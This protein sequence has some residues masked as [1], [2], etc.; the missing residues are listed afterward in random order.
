MTPETAQDE[1]GWIELMSRLGLSDL[2]VELL[3]Q[4][5]THPSYVAESGTDACQS[6]Q[7]LEFL[8][9]TVLDAAVA[10]ELYRR[11]PEA[12]EGWLTR[13]K[14]AA[15][16]TSSLAAVARKLD[17]GLHL[18]LGK[19]EET[20][21]GRQKTS[22]LADSLEAVIGA[23]FLSGGFE[24]ARC[25]VLDQLLDIIG[26]VEQESRRDAKTR[27]Q[28]LCQSLVQR[29]PEYVTIARRGPD[30]APIFDV[31]VRLAGLVLGR[32]RGGSK[33]EAQQAAAEDALSLQDQWTDR[34]Q[35][36][37]ADSS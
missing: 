35:P 11:Y 7:R 19:G 8:G 34:L 5:L 37:C 15:V 9:D 24:R 1:S 29:V 22:V 23:V 13:A 28:E 33:Q 20:T 18:R 2:D 6:N 3:Q 26:A 30:H 16:G 32:G 10:Q 25:F 14:A 27:L 21:N 4:A 12:T 36:A 31:Q 17:L